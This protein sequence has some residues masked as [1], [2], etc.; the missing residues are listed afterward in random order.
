MN[1]NEIVQ[2]E[3]TEQEVY[4]IAVETAIST[5]FEQADDDSRYH[6]SALSC[7]QKLR[8]SSIKADSSDVAES[9]LGWTVVL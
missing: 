1:K 8:T 5:L 7:K 2:C 6:H 3:F 9:F 4:M